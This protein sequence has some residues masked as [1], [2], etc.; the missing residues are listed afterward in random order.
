MC[1]SIP[2]HPPAQLPGQPQ[3]PALSP[4]PPGLCLS[5]LIPGRERG[6]AVNPS[7]EQMAGGSVTQLA[8]P[9]CPALIA[10]T[11]IRQGDAFSPGAALGRVYKP[12]SVWGGHGWEDPP[13][14][15]ILSVPQHCWPG[16]GQ[17]GPFGCLATTLSPDK[18]AALAGRSEMAA[19]E[20]GDRETGRGTA[21]MSSASCPRPP[22]HSRGP[23]CTSRGL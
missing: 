6:R 16:E 15:A 5:R 1:S 22:Q 9:L 21:L 11:T 19:C 17:D 3:G 12:T 14:A 10:N 7:P 23:L 2:A 20:Q 8:G 13:R 18:G 4:S